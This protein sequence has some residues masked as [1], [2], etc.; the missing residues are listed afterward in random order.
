MRINLGQGLFIIALMIAPV[1]DWISPNRKPE[2]AAADGLTMGSL[3]GS[4]G[5]LPGRYMQAVF[6]GNASSGTKLF[7]IPS[8]ATTDAH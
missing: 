6:A 4:T 7:M 1:T 5:E 3:V 8:L 2:I